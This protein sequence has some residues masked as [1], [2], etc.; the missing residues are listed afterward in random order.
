MVKK[1]KIWQRIV[2]NRYEI[3]KRS[4]L[5]MIAFICAT[6]LLKYIDANSY[7]PS[8]AIGMMAGLML[9]A[10]PFVF[11][12]W[13]LNI[14]LGLYYVNDLFQWYENKKCQSKKRKR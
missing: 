7:S 9:L 8:L 4:H 6:F 5:T 13:M 3:L 1:N 12:F 14:P 2:K 10:I 11:G